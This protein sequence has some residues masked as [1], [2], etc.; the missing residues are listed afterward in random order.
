MA[1]H[2]RFGLK[3]AGHT[4]A[5]LVTAYAAQSLRVMLQRGFTTVR[6]AGGAD[7]GHKLALERGIFA[8]LDCTRKKS[9]THRPLGSYDQ[10]QDTADDRPATPRKARGMVFASCR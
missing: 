1:S 3:A 10:C 2:V 8:G 7:L 9:W 6:D 5:S 4:P